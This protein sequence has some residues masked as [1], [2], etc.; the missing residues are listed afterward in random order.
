MGSSIFGTHVR[1]RAP[2]MLES[3]SQ[4]ERD[5]PSLSASPC[6]ALQNCS[7]KLPCLSKGKTLQVRTSNPCWRRMER[8][9][10]FRFTF[11]RSDKM[12]PDVGSNRIADH[13]PTP[14]ART[15]CFNAW[16]SFSDQ[17]FRFIGMML[18]VFRWPGALNFACLRSFDFAFVFVLKPAIFANL[19]SRST[20][21]GK[22]FTPTFRAH[23]R[24]KRP[25]THQKLQAHK[26]AHIG[27]GTCLMRGRTAAVL[28]R[29][30]LGWNSSCLMPGFRPHGHLAGLCL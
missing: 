23:A 2:P 5:R 30:S 18:C 4:S 16:T 8:H 22:A 13:F 9:L 14:C 10:S 11:E 12:G 26:H 24:T 28:V 6:W 27:R 21:Q 25:S 20:R 29:M 19:P 17:Y 3:E 7:F 1:F 15:P